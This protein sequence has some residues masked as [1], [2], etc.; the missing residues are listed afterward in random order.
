MRYRVLE[1]GAIACSA[2]VVWG[3]AASP[4]VVPIPH[5]QPPEPP[6]THS[7]TPA[8]CKSP[9]RLVQA[10]L[11]P[12]NLWQLN[13]SRGDHA[14]RLTADLE[15]V[16]DQV[17]AQ[18]RDLANRDRL[19]EA[20]TLLGGIPRNSQHFSP[21]Q[22]L[23]TEWS[24]ELV[25]QATQ[26][27]QQARV[28]QAL[29]L[30]QRIPTSS[31]HFQQAKSLSQQWSR[32]AKLFRQAQLAQ[33]AERWDTVLQTLKS[34]EGSPLYQS[35]PVQ[36]T[37]QAAMNRLYEPNRRLVE[38]ASS[39]TAIA[40][41]WRT[42]MPLPDPLASTLDSLPH[43]TSLDIKTDQALTW[44]TPR[45]VPAIAQS[46]TPQRDSRQPDK[47]HQRESTTPPLFPVKPPK[48]TATQQPSQPAIA[49]PESFPVEN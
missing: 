19:A 45:K 22:Q 27:Y 34:L 2:V 18:A 46:D 6:N 21:A 38:V 1:G 12:N 29:H 20:I 8:H 4:G 41:N 28:S 5:C 48:I 15:R 17:L 14:P 40:P 11:L 9:K 13:W 37:L 32:E 30:L 24:Q 7:A 42:K 43:S 26:Y 49:S 25:Q 44:A 23:Q 39:T 36:A 33:Q 3:W 47:G 31:P 10:S 16:Y 35:S